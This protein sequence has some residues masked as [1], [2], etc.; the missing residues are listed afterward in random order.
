MPIISVHLHKS[1]ALIT[2]GC[3]PRVPPS[4]GPARDASQDLVVSPYRSCT[5]PA[6][7]PKSSSRSPLDFA[8][9]HP[10][11]SKPSGTPPRGS[12]PPAPCFAK[13]H[14]REQEV[15]KE[16]PAAGKYKLGEPAWQPGS[17]P[18]PSGTFLM[19]GTDHQAKG[20]VLSN[21]SWAEAWVEQGPNKEPCV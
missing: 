17:R 20:T 6:L 14:H 21:K 7:A 18:C 8:R 12:V 13:G 1:T 15:L 4:C 19:P 3:H 11:P 9:L 2:S 16:Q 10:V 5:C